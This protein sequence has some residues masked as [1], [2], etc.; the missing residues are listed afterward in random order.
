VEATVGEYTRVG[1]GLW[2]WE[3][4]LALV[5][6]D[7]FTPDYRARNLWIGLYTSAEMRRTCPGL[8]NGSIGRMA[9]A[10][11]MPGDDAL[12]ALDRLLDH[13]LVEYDNRTYVL[14]LTQLPDALDGCDNGNVIR[15]WFGRFKT[16]PTCATRDS[17]VRLLRWMV[18][19]TNKIPSKTKGIVTREEA[20]AETFATIP[21]PAIRR[22]GVRRLMESTVQP[23][24]FDAPSRAARSFPEPSLPLSEASESGSDP[25]DPNHRKELIPGTVPEPFPNG[26][27]RIQ[28][29]DQ[30]SF[31]G[32][33]SPDPEPAV[34]E[35]ANRPR[36]ALALVPAFT[37]EA[38]IAAL[39]EGFSPAPTAVRQTV[40]DTLREAL[41][42]TIRVLDD[43]GWGH[44]ELVKA[45][46]WLA[47]SHGRSR[48]APL[49]I[50][51][52]RSE[53][54]CVWAA[55]PHA[56]TEAIQQA[57]VVEQRNADRQR[58]WSEIA[59]GA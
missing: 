13:D 3:P 49:E 26:L 11:R 19:E 12:Y 47:S 51:C 37:P 7:G 14:R 55:Y 52:P 4:F 29:Q 2:S 31:L 53:L 25:S 35:I 5:E 34:I 9:E 21:L 15:G 56:V 36:P 57:L 17:H 33:G 8:F 10:A 48:L 22:R 16:V 6:A 46:A 20:W 1:V 28:D 50:G 59:G 38:M 27:V 54:L 32:S 45:G 18:D 30:V 24:L 58:A 44:D 40:R 43:R 41:C 39:A 42:S 23:G